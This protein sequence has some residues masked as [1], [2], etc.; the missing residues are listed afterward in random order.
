MIKWNG[1]YRNGISEYRIVIIVIMSLKF[2]KNGILEL[3]MWDCY[4]GN[5]FIEMWLSRWD[6]RIETKV[7]WIRNMR[8]QSWNFGAEIM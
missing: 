4:Y 1:Y 5:A 2:F 7:M 8:K 6:Y 3:T